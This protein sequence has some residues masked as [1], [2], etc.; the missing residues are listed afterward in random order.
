MAYET[1]ASLDVS[2]GARPVDLSRP[3]HW[4][5][6][7]TPT[8]KHRPQSSL[9]R[10]LKHLIDSP[11]SGSDQSSAYLTPTH[12]PVRSSSPNRQNS[13]D[14]SWDVIEDLPLRWATDF[15]PLASPGSR[16][17][18]QSVISYAIWNGSVQGG[19]RGRLLAV[20]TKSN[21]LLYETPK[22]ERAFRF[23]KEFYTPLQPRTITFFQQSVSDL[24][25]SPT[26]VSSPSPRYHS[27]HHKRSESTTAL[28]DPRASL[29]PAI[30]YGT[31][32]S[33]FVI[34]DKKAGWIRL[35]DSA[36]G[37]IEMYAD[38]IS[39]GSHH[40]RDSSYGS[41]GS[42]KSRSFMVEGATAT[43][44]IPPVQVDLVIPSANGRD[45]TTKPVYLLTKGKQ[46]H[47]LPCPLPSVITTPPLRIIT[48]KNVP[49][50]VEA[51]LIDLSIDSQRNTASPFL[52]LTSF[53]AHGIEVQEIPVA[54]MSKG[55]GK[56]KAL[57]D[58]PIWA[59]EDIGG[60]TGLLCPGG[61]WNNPYFSYHGLS[62]TLST[63]STMSS[64]STE[65]QRLQ[66]EGLYA[67]CRKGPEDWR[68][69]WLGNSSSD[70]SPEDD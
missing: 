24:V 60:D 68:V 5:V 39:L 54:V 15:V 67:W 47:M 44:W 63:T 65:E 19:I 51:R 43:K 56:G 34:F 55:K 26:D 38:G 1:I 52:Q 16:L 30:S 17:L 23:V 36:V 70:G 10:G 31:Q 35:A 49:S 7:Q 11:G 41:V 9:A 22:G 13:D 42:R 21:I 20:A 18:N 4:T 64:M 37:E 32:L 46:T 58:E 25:R 57:P 6:Q 69:F 59:E 3:S 66:E 48:W 40:N 27:Y 61:N 2:Q 53:G 14:S 12:S 33:L 45:S 62:R 50:H 8:K 29:A 28:R